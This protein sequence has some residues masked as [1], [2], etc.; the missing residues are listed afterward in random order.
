MTLRPAN[1]D[2]RSE[3]PHGVFIH[4]TRVLSAW[5][6]TVDGQPLESLAAETREPYRSSAG[7]PGRIALRTVHSSCVGC[8]PEEECSLE[9]LLVF[10]QPGA[11]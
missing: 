2:M 6:L 8:V 11:A 4:D 10:G 1:G 9:Q 3:L 5:T 7:F